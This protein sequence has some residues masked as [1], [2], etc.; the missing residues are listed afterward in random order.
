MVLCVN[1]EMVNS[2]GNL[3]FCFIIIMIAYSSQI[4]MMSGWS[5]AATVRLWTVLAAYYDGISIADC[6]HE[7][8]VVCLNS[9]VVNSVGNLFMMAYPLQITV[10]S[11]WWRASTVRWW[12]VWATYWVAALHPLSTHNKWCPAGTR[13]YSTRGPHRKI[14][15][16]CSTY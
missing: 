2:L 4:I 13:N 5:H 7:C 3:W 6:S 10:T 11:V 8:V 1:S 15:I 12:T 16:W 9:K 14:S